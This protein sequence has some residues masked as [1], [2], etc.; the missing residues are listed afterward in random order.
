MKAG[1][2]CGGVKRASLDLGIERTEKEVI[3]PR[4]RDRENRAGSAQASAQAVYS[5]R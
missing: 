3:W 2:L 5:H 1:R 4:F